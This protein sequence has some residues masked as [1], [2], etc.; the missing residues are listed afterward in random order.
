MRTA[1]AAAALL[2]VS[3]D[4][5]LSADL[6]IPALSVTLPRQEFPE[7]ETGNP[8]YACGP[9]AP[10][11][12]PC[13]GLTLDYDLGGQ[14]PVLNEQGVTYDLR[15]TDVALTLS[16]TQ[17]VTG[18]KDLS[19]VALATIR[20]LD[21]PALPDSGT[22]VA[23]YVRPPLT[24]PV[25]SFAVS[26]NA[27]LDLG[28]YLDAGRLPARVELVIDSADPTPAFTADVRAGFSLEVKLDYG[29]FY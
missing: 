2:L 23:T 24:G 6:Q 5:L 15:L 13:I 10:T 17:T 4:D 27:N 19:G 16:A 26:G 9:T 25:S 18:D 29:A 11:S 1:L 14:V 21:D 28:P 7:S 12:W 22:V 8:L 20:V 3:C